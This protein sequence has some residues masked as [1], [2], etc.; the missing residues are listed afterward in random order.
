MSEEKKKLKQSYLLQN[1]V[2]TVPYD[3]H[4]GMTQPEQ[5]F[6][7]QRKGTGDGTHPKV[8]ELI[9]DRQHANG[10]TGCAICTK[11]DEYA[12]IA[13]GFFVEPDE[14]VIH[15]SGFRWLCSDC[16]WIRIASAAIANHEENLGKAIRTANKHLELRGEVIRWSPH[17]FLEYIS[18]QR[19]EYADR[20]WIWNTTYLKRRTLANVNHFRTTGIG[21]KLRPLYRTTPP[22]WGGVNGDVELL[23]HIE[24][25]AKEEVGKAEKKA[26]AS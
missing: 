15:I 10:H 19:E 14:G 11:T 17:G 22:L 2:I 25:R 1:L 18:K 13:P 23:A 9:R 7:G 3:E 16:Q 21:D 5:F 20:E 24:A 26:A 6:Y 12:I 8:V 4:L